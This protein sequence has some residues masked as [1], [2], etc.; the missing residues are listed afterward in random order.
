MISV[1]RLQAYLRDKTRQQHDIITVPPFMLFFLSTDT[2]A[3]ANYAIPDKP[4]GG[5]LYDPLTRLQAIFREHRR[6]PC[7]QFIDE[8]APAL[9]KSLH[10]AGFVEA[11]RSQIMICTRETYCL[12]PDVPDLTLATLSSESSLDEVKEGWNVNAWGFDPNASPA[13]DAEAEEFRQSLV[14]SRA[15][16]ARLNG[17]GVGAGMFTEIRDDIT[18][19]V[20]ITTLELFRRRGIAS[21]LTAHATRTAFAH[22]VEVA[23]LIA[24]NEQAGRVYERVGFRPYAT[25]LAYRVSKMK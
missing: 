23:F 6:T 19:L 7:I 22:G 16:I 11:R 4:A 9:A 3:D 21:V 10:A 13:T 15:F 17:H 24:A 18:E 8:F 12:P 5:D 2:S 14:T 25:L 20:G 1:T